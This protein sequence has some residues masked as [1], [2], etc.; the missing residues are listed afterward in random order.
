MFVSVQ[1]GSRER[2][3]IAP[4]FSRFGRGWQLWMTLMVIWTVV[5]ITYAWIDLPRAQQMAHNPQLLSKLSNE[6]ASI[7][8]GRN[9]KAEPAGSALVWSEEPRIVRMS[10]GARLTFPATATGE[11]VT[12]VKGE[13][14]Q[15]LNAE[16]GKQRGPYLLEVLAIWLAPAVLMLIAAL[17]VS[18][19]CRGYKPLLSRVISDGHL[20]F[21]MF[22]ALLMRM[23]N[24]FA[25]CAPA[26]RGAV[27]R[28]R[29]LSE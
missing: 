16:A 6:A 10:N 14:F 7:L 20:L 13:Y 24:H 28:R 29:Q 21:S 9:A 23:A 5:V 12:F 4:M 8:F 1:T 19:I 25:L 17:T 11:R 18:M 3:T 2:T 27:G 22:D 26:D 15:L